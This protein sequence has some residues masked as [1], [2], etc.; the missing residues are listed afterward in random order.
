MLNRALLQL[1]RLSGF[2]KYE[3]SQLW[4]GSADLQVSAQSKLHA[5][6]SRVP[7]LFLMTISRTNRSNAQINL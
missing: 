7:E 5:V 4:S 3:I 6:K 1:T 2:G